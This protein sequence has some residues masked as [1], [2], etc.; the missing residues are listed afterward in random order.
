MID[1]SDP[2]TFGLVYTVGCFVLILA[3]FGIINYIERKKVE[4]Q[5]RSRLQRFTKT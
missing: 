2:R 5:V 3:A 1:L 4:R